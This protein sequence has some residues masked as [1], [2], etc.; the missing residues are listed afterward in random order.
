MS[1][2]L[3]SVFVYTA[4]WKVAIQRHH[5]SVS[6]LEQAAGLLAKVWSKGTNTA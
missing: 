1:H 5:A 4:P 3:R 2:I 6:V